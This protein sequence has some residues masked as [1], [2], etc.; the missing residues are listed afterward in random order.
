MLYSTFYSLLGSLLLDAPLG[1]HLAGRGEDALEV[2]V[3]LETRDEGVDHLALF[4]AH[5]LDPPN[6]VPF[7]P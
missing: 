7:L 2:V 5:N 3:E 4:T 6:V 1:Q